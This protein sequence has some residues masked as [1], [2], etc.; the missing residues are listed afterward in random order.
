VRF[1][2]KMVCNGMNGLSGNDT[3]PLGLMGY[4]MVYRF[5]GTQG[6]GLAATLGY[7]TEPL[8]G[9]GAGRHCQ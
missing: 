9:R 5:H 3:T 8:R 6:S 1:S 2:A 4:G 7:I